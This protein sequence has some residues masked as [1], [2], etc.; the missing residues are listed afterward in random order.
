MT[1]K[2]CNG[3]GMVAYWDG[4]ALA[5]GMCPDESH[6]TPQPYNGPVCTYCSEPLTGQP[7]SL[8]ELF[9]TAHEIAWGLHHGAEYCSTLCAAMADRDNWSD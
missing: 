6:D 7:L 9:A 8:E 3:S 2:T 4:S 1:C 5:G